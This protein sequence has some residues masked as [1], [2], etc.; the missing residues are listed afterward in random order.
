[1]YSVVPK[2]P[3]IFFGH[4]SPMN[5]IEENEFTR[6]WSQSSKNM[7]KPKAIL[8]ISAHW[9]TVGT[10]VTAMTKPRTIHDFGGFPWELF[11]V[12]YPAQGS[13]WL[14]D[15]VKKIIKT[16]NLQSDF[17]WGLDH[18]AWS[19]LRH[20]YPQ[21]DIPIVQLSLDYTQDAQY[22]FDLAQQLI[23]L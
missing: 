23:S 9:E 5:A 14:V 22:H 16:T 2:L 7:P 3:V 18:G 17:D 19:V 11:A 8:C 6:G 20:L 12:Q 1:M 13:D 21:A 15:E 4:G 10:F